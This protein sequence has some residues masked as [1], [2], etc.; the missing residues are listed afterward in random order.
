[1]D[2]L[3][4]EQRAAVLAV[5]EA[6]DPYAGPS[7]DAAKAAATEEVRAASERVRA[8]YY[9]TGKEIDIRRLAPG[10]TQAHLDEL[11]AFLDGTLNLVANQAATEIEAAPDLDALLGIMT[12][13]RAMYGQELA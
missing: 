1:M 10:F 4:D 12:G 11:N 9:P 6:H 5:Y 3:T 7:L 2:A 8:R 13:Y